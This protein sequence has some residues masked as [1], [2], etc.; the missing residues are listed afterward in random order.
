MVAARSDAVSLRARHLPLYLAALAAGAV[1]AFALSASAQG[2]AQPPPSASFTAGDNYWYVT[3]TIVHDRHDCRGRHGDVQ[4]P[5]G[6]Q[7]AQ[8]DA[9]AARTELMRSP[10]CPVP[11]PTHPGAPHAA[12][13]PRARY[14]FICT[15]HSGHGR[16]RVGRRRRARLPP[17]RRQRA[18]A[19][20]LRAATRRAARPRSRARS[21]S[22]SRAGSA[23][24]PCAAP[25]RHARTARAWRSRRS[26][27]TACW[28][29]AAAQARSARCPSARCGSRC[30]SR[31][32]RASP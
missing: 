4:Q 5:H 23:A 13:T 25:S 18:P 20:L 1:L 26:S 22:R 8:R 12:S 30:R 3:G 10:R 28:R 9:S 31:A 16:H 17:R 29:G 19:R 24:P 7:R 27:R 11:R 15:Q 21:P 14:S 6:E 2:G 32:G